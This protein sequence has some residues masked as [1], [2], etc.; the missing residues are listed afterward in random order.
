MAMMNR[1]LKKLFDAGFRYVFI[2]E[3]T[4]MEDFIDSLPSF[5]MCSPP[6]E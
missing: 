1:D 3:V 5:P 6:W 2:D 4:L